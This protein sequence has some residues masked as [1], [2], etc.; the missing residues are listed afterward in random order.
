[1]HD[2]SQNLVSENIPEWKLKLSY[3]YVNFMN[4]I[5]GWRILEKLIIGY[6]KLSTF[7]NS[8][9]KFA[10]IRFNS[11]KTAIIINVLTKGYIFQIKI[12]QNEN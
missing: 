10:E 11:Q 1:M 6:F 12:K 7:L 3:F 8:C 2:D 5:N 4:N 9:L